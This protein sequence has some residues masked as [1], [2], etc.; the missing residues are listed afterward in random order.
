MI[1]N[2]PRPALDSGCESFSFLFFFGLL[3][4]R[5]DHILHEFTAA[6]RTLAFNLTNAATGH[7]AGFEA[8]DAAF[9]HLD[10]RTEPVGAEHPSRGVESHRS[11]DRAL[12]F[13]SAQAR[14]RLPISCDHVMP[15]TSGSLMRQRS[16]GIACE[17]LRNCK[18]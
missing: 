11:G 16:N 13:F 2:S 1:L 3:R 7:V 4:V 9:A 8:D 5:G 12:E 10:M 18:N 17:S 15:P 6:L 14:M